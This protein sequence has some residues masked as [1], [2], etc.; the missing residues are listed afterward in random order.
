MT[1]KGD[2]FSLAQLHILLVQDNAEPPALERNAYK[3][4]V[5]ELRDLETPEIFNR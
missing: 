1:S 3:V 5:P 2:S 4:G